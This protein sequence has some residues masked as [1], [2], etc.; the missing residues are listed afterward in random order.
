MVEWVARMVTPA[1]DL[2]A[3]VF[4]RTV[5]L[6]P[7]PVASA[8]L[9]VSSLGVHECRVDGVPVSPEVL[10]PGWSSYDWRRRYRSHDVTLRSVD[11]GPG[12]LVTTP[13]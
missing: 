10:S 8:V 7:G 11:V 4:R 3:P 2:V 6:D 13:R 5:A 1:V 12:M 9:H